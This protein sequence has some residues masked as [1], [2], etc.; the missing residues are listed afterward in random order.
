MG[1]ILPPVSQKNNQANSDYDYASAMT[2]DTSGKK[3]S[4]PS[5]SYDYPPSSA[6]SES[7][8]KK[9]KKSRWD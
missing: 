6:S 9:K 8:G 7:S 5:R 1:V 4:Q 2:R 3:S